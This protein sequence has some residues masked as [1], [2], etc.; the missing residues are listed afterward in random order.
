MKA[1]EDMVKDDFYNSEG[2]EQQNGGHS[3]GMLFL[4]GQNSLEKDDSWGIAT[5][6]DRNRPIRRQPVFNGRTVQGPPGI[7]V[8]RP[9]FCLGREEDKK[10]N[11]DIMAVGNSGEEW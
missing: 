3:S 2:I 6:R 4:G 7:D 5:G 9:M 10:E 8:A 1:M 11:R